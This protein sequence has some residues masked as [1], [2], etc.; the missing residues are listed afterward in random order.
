MD[1]DGVLAARLATQRLSGPPAS[2]PAPAVA[3]L[4]CVQAQDA[5]LARA[6]IALRCGGTDADVRAAVARG[7][8]V[9][10]HV[11]RPT[12]HYLAAEDLRWLL[13]LTSPKVES[14]MA[15]RHRQLSLTAA[16]VDA[17]LSVVADALAGRRFAPRPSLGTALAGAG[18]LDRDDP[19]F[20]QQVGH[21][22]LLGELRALICS[23]PVES[24]EH[25]YAL[26]EEV[27][28][29]SRPREHREALA[30][31]VRRFVTGHGPVAPSDLVRWARVTLGEVRTALRDLDGHLAP[32]VV[33]GQE[34]WHAPDALLPASR[35][36][37]AWLVSTFD[38]VF[39]SYRTVPWPRS[40]GH[41][42]GEDPYR[43]AEAG[44]GVVLCDLEDVGAWKRTRRSG[45]VRIDLEL[46]TTLSSSA[47]GAIDDAAATL[48][49][50]IA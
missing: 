29:A 7:E 16:R 42:A 36:Q 35:A 25:H 45:R 24:T 34:L 50:V 32:L 44:G 19:L 12:W 40:A 38:E 21:I 4:L 47:L 28:P 14:G 15:S 20:G 39:L 9:R 18:V 43:F 22:L 48:A 23:A 30:E 6:M 5:P 33:D 26:V 10:T 27:V 3:E 11:L 31:L 17:G 37:R 8:L 2:G 46:D 1:R 41:P 13:A 49:T